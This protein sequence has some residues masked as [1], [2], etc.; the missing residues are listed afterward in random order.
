MAIEYNL[1]VVAGSL[2]CLRPLFIRLGLSKDSY[3]SNSSGNKP[4]AGADVENNSYPLKTLDNSSRSGQWRNKFGRLNISNRVQGES[5]LDR[6]LV[7]DHQRLD[8]TDEDSE[9]RKRIFLNETISQEK[10]YRET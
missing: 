7:G 9:S 10:G 1:G 2:A 3:A 6:T 4:S 8:D 5:V